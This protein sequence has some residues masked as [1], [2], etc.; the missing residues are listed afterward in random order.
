LP[1]TRTI[2]IVDDEVDLADTCAR[3]LKREGL[4]CVVAYNMEDGLS[5]FDSMKPTLVISDITLPS[6]DGFEIARYVR[7]RSPGTPVILMTAYH[8]AN[9]ADEARQAGAAGYLRKP[10]ANAELVAAVRSFIDGGG[11]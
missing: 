11:S 7:Q 3:L 2:L 6:G 8:S 5:L 9:S 10:F 1:N 4:E